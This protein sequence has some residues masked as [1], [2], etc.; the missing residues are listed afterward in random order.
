MET[1]NITKLDINTSTKTNE[2]SFRFVSKFQNPDLILDGNKIK[3]T[4]KAT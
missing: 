2:D 3:A 4:N 1:E